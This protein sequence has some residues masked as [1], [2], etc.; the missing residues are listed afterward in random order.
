VAAVSFFPPGIDPRDPVRGA[1]ELVEIDAVSGPA[2]FIVG[3]D[4]RFRDTLGRDWWGSQLITAD[5]V[6]LSRGGK[7][8]GASLVLSWFQDPS[9]S[10]LIEDLKASGDAEIE[11]RA[12]RFYLQHIETMGE[13]YAPVH[14]PILRATRI[15]TSLRFEIQGDLARRIV[16]TVE[17]PFARRRA[18]RSLFL[19]VAD[20]NRLIGDTDNPS[21]EF[22]PKPVPVERKIWA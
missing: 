17:G 8:P 12:V 19:T 2:R 9:A 4:G 18:V 16:L 21:L 15:A 22:M 14:A 20:H 5:P 6:E 3:T 13:F 11:G 7:A 1:L 10:D